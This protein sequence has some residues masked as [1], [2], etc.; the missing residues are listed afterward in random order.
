MGFVSKGEWNVGLSG[1]RREKERGAEK[2]SRRREGRASWSWKKERERGK[3]VG[4]KE[5]VI[6]E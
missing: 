4:E 5:R 1:E 2:I 6:C 3:N